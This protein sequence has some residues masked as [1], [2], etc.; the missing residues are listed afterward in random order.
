MTTSENATLREQLVAAM[1]GDQSH[2]EFTAA[3]ED[4]PVDLA[5]ARPPGVAHTAWQLLEHMR[6]AQHD[7]L[8]FSRNPHH[9]S[10]QFPEGYWPP[11]EAPPDGIA[12]QGSVATFRKEAKEMEDLILD[13]NHDLYLPIDGGNGQNLLREAF[14][15]ASHNS[16]HL[17]QLEFLKKMLLSKS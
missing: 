12:W 16:Y 17:G 9:K 2:L 13:A 7:I 15:L 6:I 11:T 1:R 8:E 3:V 4:F 5:G 10:P 14:V